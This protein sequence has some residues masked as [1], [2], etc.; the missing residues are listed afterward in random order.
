MKRLTAIL[1]FA[2]SIAQAQLPFDAGQFIKQLKVGGPLPEKLLETRSVVFYPSLMYGELE[3]AQKGFQRAGVD[4]VFYLETDMLAAG[5]DVSVN[6]AQY[7]N[8]REIGYILILQRN[9]KDYSLMAGTYN[10]RANLF[11]PTESLWTL[12][13]PSLYQLMN[14]LY[15]ISAGTLRRGNF[16]INDFPETDIRIAAVTGRRN[17]FYA[18]DLKVDML[19]VPKFGDAAMDAELE[20]LMKQLPVK[21]K[22][23]DPALSEAELRKQGFRWVIRFVHAKGRTARQ[24]LGYGLAKGQSAVASVARGENNQEEVKKFGVD[25]IVY[26]FYMKRFEGSEVFLG[27]NWDADPAWQQALLNQIRGFKTEFN[28]Q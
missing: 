3:A 20:E 2:C 7:L 10:R 1:L 8:T 16:L 26:K 9:E 24:L 15:Q 22:L 19:A 25:E 17:E 27:R 11:E 13:A 12:R 4:A 28:L 14:Q 18:I 23:T 5:R 21:Y 6:L